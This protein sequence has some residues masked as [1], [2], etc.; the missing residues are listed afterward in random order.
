MTRGRAGF[1]LVELL[2]GIILAGVVGMAI[3]RMV[4]TTQRVSRA[5]TQQTDMQ[6]SM[7]TGALLLP[8]EL[9]EIGFDHMG[10]GTEVP[11]ILDARADRLTIRV[12]RGWAIMCGNY[13]EEAILVRLPVI[14]YRNPTTADSL[15]LFTEN[16][17][18]RGSDDQWTPFRTSEIRVETCPEDGEPAL[19][20]KQLTPNDAF[21]DGAS[22]SGNGMPIGT[23]IRNGSP[24]RFYEV[25]EY[26]LYQSGGRW[27]LGAQSLTGGEAAPQPV[28]GPLRANGGF[29]LRYLDR[30]NQ[31]INAGDAARYKDIRVVEITLRGETTS[32][33]AR[34]D[35]GALAIKVDS[36]VTRVALRN[37]LRP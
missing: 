18:D 10:D 7:R 4:M 20:F 35:R 31:V 26:S 32:P 1:T 16:E 24:V 25:M 30:D 9:R 15:L 8:A 27:W 37:A 33:V 13:S 17:Y 28:L 6:A 22:N 2:I 29:A 34:S 19:E 3:T 23:R 11:D 21:K 5:Q 14:G 12:M 36:L